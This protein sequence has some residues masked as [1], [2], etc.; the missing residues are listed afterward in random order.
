MRGC[1]WCGYYGRAFGAGSAQLT[2]KAKPYW[3]PVFEN[4]QTK[5]GR[6]W[7]VRREG[8]NCLVAH[9]VWVEKWMEAKLGLVSAASQLL[10][11]AAPNQ[12]FSLYTHTAHTFPHITS[13]VSDRRIQN[14]QDG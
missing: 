14:G 7:W 2:L 5:P 9:W 10:A 13:L 3:S 1:Y 11:Q 4:D 8:Q 6:S 12:C